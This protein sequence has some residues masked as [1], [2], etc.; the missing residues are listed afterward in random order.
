MRLS[1]LVAG[2]IPA[3]ALA[4][5]GWSSYDPD[6]PISVT[7]RL[8]D[9]N[10]SNPHAGAKIAYANRS[11]NVVLA[12]IARM[13]ARGLTPAMLK[14]G[15]PVTLE[16]QVRTDGTAEMKIQRLTIDGKAYELL[17]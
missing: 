7:G 12:P 16:A 13:E 11:W 4:H 6:K 17:R 5:H 15:K 14:S 2:L 10:W 8:T 1:L 9:V 3:A